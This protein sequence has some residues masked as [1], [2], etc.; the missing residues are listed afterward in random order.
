MSET[1]DAEDCGL[2]TVDMCP[3]SDK[4]MHM[5]ACECQICKW[6]KRNFFRMYSNTFAITEHNG[7][8]KLTFIDRGFYVNPFTVAE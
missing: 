7:D 5:D 1:I 6:R 4:G 2:N 8:G 3:T